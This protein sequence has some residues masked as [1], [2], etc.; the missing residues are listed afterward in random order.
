MKDKR[1]QVRL[2]DTPECYAVAVA[3]IRPYIWI[4]D[5][6]DD[7]YRLTLSNNDLHRLLAALKSVSR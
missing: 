6:Y 7:R 3:G 4:G 5:R 1:K 2:F